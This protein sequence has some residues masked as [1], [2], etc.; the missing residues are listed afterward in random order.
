MAFVLLLHF[1]ICFS[2][3]LLPWLLPCESSFL[4]P[5]DRENRTGGRKGRGQGIGEATGQREWE[6]VKDI[7]QNK[8]NWRREAAKGMFRNGREGREGKRERERA[9]R[10]DREMERTMKTKKD[11]VMRKSAPCMPVPLFFRPYVVLEK[12]KGRRQ[13]TRK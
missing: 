9:R 5:S 3:L 6:K 13:R 4:L 10:R 2:F 12:R 7:N 11:E 8:H 1:S